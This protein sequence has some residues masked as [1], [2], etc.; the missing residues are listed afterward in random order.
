[1]AWDAQQLIFVVRE[2]FVSKT[3]A[4]EI[5]CGTIEPGRP[6]F[7]ES[8]TP[9]G[10]VIFSDG[11]EA[12]FLDFNAGAVAQINLAERQARLVVTGE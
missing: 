5:V 12:D 11:V 6:L 3:T 10:G 4:A 8:H 9:S 7:L 2:P 1:M